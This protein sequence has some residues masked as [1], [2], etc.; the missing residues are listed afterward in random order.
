M[1]SA[2]NPASGEPALDR[3]PGDVRTV[4]AAHG[5]TGTTRLRRVEGLDGAPWFMLDW[6]FPPGTGE[7]PHHHGDE[8]IGCEQYYVT[9][10]QVTVIVGGVRYDLAEGDAIAVPRTMVRELTNDSDRTA[11][12]LLLV[13]RL[14]P[15]R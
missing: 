4:T 1:T 6:E 15:H 9:Q 3:A 12:I 8:P 14:V 13:E 10:G 7:G 2:P 11:R 5:G